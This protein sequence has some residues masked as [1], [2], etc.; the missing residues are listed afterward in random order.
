MMREVGF[1]SGIENYARHIE[2]RDP[3]SRPNTLIDYFPEDFL[4]VLDE[5]HVTVPQLNGMYEGD[6]SRKRTLVEHGFRLPSALDNR[7]LRFD[8]FLDVGQS[9]RVHERNARARSSSARAAN[10]SSNSCGPPA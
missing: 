3:G 2:G 10:R 4:V 1:C 7:P 6:M 5:S 9:G 8:E